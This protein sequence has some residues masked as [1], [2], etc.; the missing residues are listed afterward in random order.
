M[1]IMSHSVCS[2]D[3][4]M[5]MKKLPNTDW[6][7]VYVRSGDDERRDRRI[8]QFYM[9]GK[10]EKKLLYECIGSSHCKLY[11]A[12]EEKLAERGA[13]KKAISGEFDKVQFGMLPAEARRLISA[14]RTGMENAQTI[15]KPAAAGFFSR[16]TVLA[17]LMWLAGRLEFLIIPE[18]GRKGSLRLA[19]W[20]DAKLD[21]GRTLSLARSNFRRIPGTE[22]GFKVPVF[23]CRG[24]P[25]EYAERLDSEM[26]PC[27]PEK[28]KPEQEQRG[29]DSSAPIR[30]PG[31]ILHS[32]TE[33]EREKNLR[34]HATRAAKQAK[35]KKKC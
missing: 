1:E 33:K 15:G 22:A 16:G 2:D 6:H 19:F 35:K 10:C 20:K 27:A 12:D 30:E 24:F 5:A 25:A 32:K 17:C 3:N 34:R 29:G 18:L 13:R 11:K 8:C 26:R 4:D 21:T 28:K 23:V 14:F 7:I 31:F 9:D